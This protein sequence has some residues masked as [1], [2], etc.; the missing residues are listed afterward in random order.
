VNVEEFVRFILQA[1]TR[2]ERRDRLAQVPFHLRD[3][4]K[5]RVEMVWQRRNTRSR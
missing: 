4:V 3:K 5:A 2:Q 1:R